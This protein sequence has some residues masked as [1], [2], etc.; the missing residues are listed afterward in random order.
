MSE[1]S[2]LEAALINQQP[3]EE[4][5]DELTPATPR[6]DLTWPTDPA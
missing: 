2:P 6:V 4:T 5:R 1:T 3:A